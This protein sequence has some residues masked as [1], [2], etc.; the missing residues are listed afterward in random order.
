MLFQVAFVSPLSGLCLYKQR[1]KETLSGVARLCIAAGELWGWWWKSI[2]SKL[3]LFWICDRSSVVLQLNADTIA[4][5]GKCIA[6]IINLWQESAKNPNIYFSSLNLFSGIRHGMSNFVLQ[7]GNLVSKC[8]HQGVKA[9]QTLAVLSNL[10][11]LRTAE[12]A[13]SQGRSS[14]GLISLLI[15]ILSGH[16]FWLSALRDNDYFDTALL[17]SAQYCK[18]SVSTSLCCSLKLISLYSWLSEVQK[19]TSMTFIGR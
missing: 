15:A 14:M 1:I 5:N 8:I 18:K 2:P 9:C 10:N 19:R 13:S 11:T 4:V 12:N 6:V 7:D 17:S 16:S 3:V